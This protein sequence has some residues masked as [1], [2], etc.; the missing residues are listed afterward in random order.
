MKSSPHDPIWSGSEEQLPSE[1]G[2]TKVD[3]RNWKSVTEKMLCSRSCI[4]APRW[5]GEERHLLSK[6]CEQ[7]MVELDLEL[8]LQIPEGLRQMQSMIKEVKDYV[9]L[10]FN[11]VRDTY[12]SKVP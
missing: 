6:C 10:T 8:L 12:N 3:L 7:S 5:A 1:I 4:N 11:S 2:K 9:H